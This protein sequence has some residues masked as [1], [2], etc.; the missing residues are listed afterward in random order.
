MTGYLYQGGQQILGE[1]S[2]KSCQAIKILFRCLLN[3]GLIAVFV[4]LPILL[5][6]PSKCL[7]NDTAF[8]AS[9]RGIYVIAPRGKVDNLHHILDTPGIAGVSLSVTWQALEPQQGTYQ[10][11]LLDDQIAKVT[12]AGKRIS[13]RILPGISTPDWVYAGGTQDITFVDKNPYHDQRFYPPGHRYRTLGHTLRIPVP[14]DMAFLR[15]WERFVAASGRRYAAEPALAMV[16]ITGP[17]RHSAE[18]HLPKAKEDKARWMVLAYTPQKLIAAWKRCID[19]FATAFPHTPLVLNLSPV[20]FHDGVMRAVAQYGYA[21]YGRRLL[22]QNNILRADNHGM[23]RPDWEVLRTYA[24]KTT[25]GF[26][27]GLLRLKHRE[28]LSQSERRRMRRSNFEGMFAQGLMLGAQYFEIGRA[29]VR[30]FPD[31][32]AKVAAQLQD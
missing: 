9:V 29:E 6:V 25:I 8:A 19:A 23:K 1:Q 5:L 26:Q 18:M 7:P 32:V 22:M 3:C 12:K 30:D 11:A 10:W 31:V 4:I 15:A 13:L 28:G 20:I 27:R 14:W 24:G 17:T 16:H 21:T 2:S